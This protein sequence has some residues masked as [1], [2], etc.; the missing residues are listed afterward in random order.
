MPTLVSRYQV[1]TARVH[2]SDRIFSDDRI[3]R[4]NRE[5]FVKR[6]RYKQSIEWIA[7]EI[8]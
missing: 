5:F 6:L 1:L 2:C 8:G 4:Y 3:D 7:M